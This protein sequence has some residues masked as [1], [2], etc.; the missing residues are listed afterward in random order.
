MKKIAVVTGV[1]LLSLVLIL[2]ALF[3]VTT[4]SIEPKAYFEEGYYERTKNSLDSVELFTANEP[5]QAGFA[6]VSITPGLN[7]ATD[8]HLEGNFIAMPLAGYGGREG[9]PAT[10]VHD[11]I[12]VSSAALKVGAKTIVFVTA[13]LLI[14]PPNVVDSVTNLLRDTGLAREQVF[15]SATHTH[16]SVGAWGPGFVG[17]TFAGEENPA[18][19]KWLARRIA[20]AIRESMAD[21]R[22]GRIGTGNFTIPIYTR[23]RLIGKSGTKNNDFSYIVLEQTGSRRA[24]LGS[25]SAHAT[26]LGEDTWEISAD[27]PGYWTRK[28]ERMG[29]D[30]ALFFAGSVGSQGPL[31]KGKGFERAKDIGEGLADSLNTRLSTLALHDSVLFSCVSLKMDLPDFNIRLTRQRNISTSVSHRL[32]PLFGDTYLQVV[33]LGNMIWITTPSDFSGEYALQLKNSLGAL[34]YDANVTSFNGSYVGYIVPPRYFYLDEYEP[35]IMGWFGP[36]M[37]EFTMD[38]IR[39]L[40]REV[41]ETDNI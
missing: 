1:I 41:T 29:F 27:Y 8:D 33:R 18:V 25:Y 11:S 23:N 26:V 39:Q 9:K 37:G 5:V 3:F 17:K 31:G 4:S 36:N 32:L 24:I 14:M 6:K 13:D 21:L 7:S 38:M 28:M 35:K 2:L 22:P 19:V 40:L 12:F 16:A 30:F 20:Q 10:G 15:Y 34:G